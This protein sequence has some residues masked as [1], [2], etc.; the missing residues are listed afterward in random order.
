[1]KVKKG[2]FVAIYGEYLNIQLILSTGSGKSSL[3]YSLLGILESEN[4]E[5]V[6]LFESISV[7]T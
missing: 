1:M 6:K 5:S 4:K 2:E 7:C 3:L